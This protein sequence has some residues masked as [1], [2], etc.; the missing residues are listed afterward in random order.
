MMFCDVTF[1]DVTFCAMMGLVLRAMPFHFTISIDEKLLERLNNQKTREVAFGEFYDLLSRH[2]Y[3]YALR[4]TSCPSEASD[5]TQET[6]IR[7]HSHLCR[8]RSYRVR[9]AGPNYEASKSISD[10][11]FESILGKGQL[12]TMLDGRKRKAVSHDHVDR[13]IS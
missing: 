1:C 6:F 9:C 12:K 8:E 11:C 5:I 13:F 7:V 4:M 10:K 3:M 2:V